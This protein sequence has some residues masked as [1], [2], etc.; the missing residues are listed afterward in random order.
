AHEHAR[1]EKDEAVVLGKRELYQTFSLATGVPEML[2]RDDAP[3]HVGE[4]AARLSSRI[5]GQDRA[6]LALAET[7]G[8]VKAA[9]QPANKPLA[10]F[11]FVGPTGVGKTELARALAELLF[12]SPDRMVRFDMSELAGADAAER[13]IGSSQAGG[14]LFTRRVREQPFC[15][16][17]LDEIEKAH[18]SVFDLLLQ[19]TGEGRLTD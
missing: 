2:L 16:V 14:G 4:V 7:I 18:P 15:V 17:L 6:V 3:L 19:V 5:I 11:L 1:G 8:V 13:L 9:L 12:G 10:T